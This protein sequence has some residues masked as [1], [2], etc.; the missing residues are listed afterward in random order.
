M[1]PPQIGDPAPSFTLPTQ[2]GVPICLCSLLRGGTPLL[3]I[4]FPGRLAH[5]AAHARI[6]ALARL[7]PDFPAARFLVIVPHRPD[8][9]K[10]YVEEV[11]TPFD[12]LCDDDG[13][14]TAAYGVPR[15]FALRR[16]NRPGLFGVDA[17]GVIRYRR[18]DS[19]D[20][21]AALAVAIAEIDAAQKTNRRAGS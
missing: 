2:H 10:R 12:L 11:G 18:L 7:A 1:M 4:A 3:L 19:W 15:R 16:D 5:A 13:H 17:A 6:L 14:V 9:A 8:E 20:D 21:S